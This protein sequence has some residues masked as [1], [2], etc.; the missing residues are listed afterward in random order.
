[1]SDTS[2][3]DLAAMLP[4]AEPVLVSPPLISVWRGHGFT[5]PVFSGGESMAGMNQHH[6]TENLTVGQHISLLPEATI[7]WFCADG[8]VCLGMTE[9]REFLPVCRQSADLNSCPSP[10]GF[11]WPSAD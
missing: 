1:M 8:S 6:D 3:C 2:H 4:Y 11:A 10:D 7:A 5:F 9:V